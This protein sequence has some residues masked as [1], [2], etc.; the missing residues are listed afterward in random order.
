MLPVEGSLGEGLDG[1]WRRTLVYGLAHYGKSLFW[2]VGEMLFAFFLTEVG[3]LPPAAMGAVL[4]LGL[5]ASALADLVAGWL[6]RHVLA[7]VRSA[8]RLQLVGAAGSSL[9]LAAV[10]ASVWA[11]ASARVAFAL[12]VCLAFRLA[13]ALYDLPQ[14]TL[15]TLATSDAAGRTR[16]VAT[17]YVFTGLAGLTVASVTVPLLMSGAAAERP[18]RYVGLAGVLSVVAIGSAV[19]L[20]WVLR[21]TETPS[22][23]AQSQAWSPW[24]VLG[25]TSGL[26]VA[27]MFVES[28]AG[29]IFSRLEPYYAAY[30]LRDPLL[31]G[32][33]LIAVSLGGA[34]SQ[35]LWAWLSRGLDRASMVGVTAVALVLSAGLF[36]LLSPL[37]GAWPLAC[38][39]LFG[40]ANS[41]LGLSMWSAFGDAVAREARGGEGLAYACF[42]A[43][44]KLALA[45][46]VWGLGLVLSRLDYR[47]AE[48]DGLVLLMSA[49]PVLAGLTCAATAVLWRLRGARPSSATA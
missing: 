32:G 36:L 38:G 8:A 29:P 45:L 1:H 2:S 18:L 47:G 37:G 3:G 13:Y 21:G 26:L 22:Q 23:P 31:S 10:F 4:G 34:G 14:N 7:D 16:V 5:V 41:G 20:S 42:T 17:R 24:R 19:A 9:A 12:A 15:V 48:S 40:A 43:S 35:P 49:P 39:L 27:L 44:S 6:L 25:P 33:V 30:V 11:P 28:L 46:G